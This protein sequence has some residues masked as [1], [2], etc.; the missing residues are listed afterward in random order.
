MNILTDRAAG[1]VGWR[2][3][4][5]SVDK[6]NATVEDIFRTARLKNGDRALYDLIAD[7]KGLKSEF[8]LFVD[9]ELLRGA[10]DWTRAVV[11]SEQFHVCDWPMGD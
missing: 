7:D 1:V 10:M 9:G 11:D 8:G 4:E 2:A 5:I 6:P 3:R